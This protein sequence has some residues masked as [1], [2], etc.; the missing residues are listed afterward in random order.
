MLC[1]SLSKEP[2]AWHKIMLNKYQLTLKEEK[3][4]EWEKEEGINQSFRSR[5]RL[6]AAWAADIPYC[7]SPK[8]QLQPNSN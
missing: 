2:G 4:V 8:E 6:N 7:Q 5:E 1:I 3:R